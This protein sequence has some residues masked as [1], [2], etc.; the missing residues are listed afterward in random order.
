MNTQTSTVDLA[1][2]DRLFE[3]AE[4]AARPSFEDSVP[5][6]E[7]RVAVEQAELTVA[8]SSGNP[9]LAWRLRIL[10]GAQAGRL[11]F[12]NRAITERTIPW[13]KEEL[14]K[15]GLKLERLSELSGHI[16]TLPGKELRI[17]K[18]SRDGNTNVYFQWSGPRAVE[19]DDDLP[20]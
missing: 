10:D 1:Q 9:M 7:Y 13:V 20:F 14:V 6:G 2:F 4:T 3:S 15:C 16:H 5:D 8:R 11:V 12:K 18:R 19:S 17:A